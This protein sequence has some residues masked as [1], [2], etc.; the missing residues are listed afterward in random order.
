M[1][2]S[3]VIPLYHSI[4]FVSFLVSLIMVEAPIQHLIPLCNNL[5]DP[6][7][8]LLK[9][10]SHASSAIKIL[11]KKIDEGFNRL[12]DK[13]CKLAD[14]LEIKIAMASLGQM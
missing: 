4:T 6:Q 7:V 12:S 5:L 2:K 13:T 1:P 11:E 10:A 3:N 14:D 9:A 8:N